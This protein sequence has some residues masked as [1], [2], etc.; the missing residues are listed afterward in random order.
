M[1]DRP[2]TFDRD[3]AEGSAELADRQLAEQKA[4]KNKA[5]NK[6]DAPADG[7]SRKAAT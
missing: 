1:A 3:P 5:P 2:S 4:E 6:S 7:E